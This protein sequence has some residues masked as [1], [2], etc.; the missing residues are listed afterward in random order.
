MIHLRSIALASVL[1]VTSQLAAV[2]TS[3]RT[4]PDSATIGSTDVPLRGADLLK[5]KWVI[6][7]YVAG[8]Y[9]PKAT[10]ATPAAAVAATPKR[11][12][13]HYA[14]DI[15][16]EKMVEATDETIGNGL[17]PEQVTAVAANLKTWN[18]LYPAPREN[19]VLTFDHLPGGTLIMTLNGKELGRLTDDVFAQALFAIWIGKQPVKE[20]LRDTLIGK[21]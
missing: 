12:L 20:S 3:G 18:A 8:L 16:R 4:I 10:E 6:S 14:R 15:P 1:F 19:D 2:E 11:L 21:N 7:L 9:L 17:T 13:M 5:Y